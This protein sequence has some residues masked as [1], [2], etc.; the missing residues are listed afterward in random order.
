MSVASAH[1]LAALDEF[2]LLRENL[3]PRFRLVVDTLAEEHLALMRLAIG[4]DPHT[5]EEEDA[6]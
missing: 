3:P 1:E 6:R 5:D 2:A 4:Q